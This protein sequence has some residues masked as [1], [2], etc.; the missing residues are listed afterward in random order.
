MTN[1]YVA[2]TAPE[3]S[4]VQARCH[5][6]P[7][8]MAAV[9][10]LSSPTIANRK[11]TPASNISREDTLAL[12]QRCR[13]SASDSRSFARGRKRVRDDTMGLELV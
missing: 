7:C 11:K 3:K 6:F 10:S 9:R 2:E 12:R 8:W 5:Q 13:G 1:T 4:P